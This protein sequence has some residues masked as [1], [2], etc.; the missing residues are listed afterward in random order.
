[1]NSKYLAVACIGLVLCAC[2]RQVGCPI[3]A[4]VKAVPGDLRID[5]CIHTDSSGLLKV[6]A[7]GEYSYGFSKINEDLPN[8]SSFPKKYT[9]AKFDSDRWTLTDCFEE[10]FEAERKANLKRGKRK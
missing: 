8:F 1:M 3:E 6:V 7:I 5:Q 2:S 4:Q 10:R 9:Q